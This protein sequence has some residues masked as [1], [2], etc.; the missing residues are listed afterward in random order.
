MNA[1]ASISTSI[2]G[3]INAL[4]STSAVAG[5]HL[6]EHF[7]SGLVLSCTVTI[8]ADPQEGARR[9]RERYGGIGRV[10]TLNHSGRTGT[11]GRISSPRSMPQRGLITR[12]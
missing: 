12:P 10:V 1:C 5:P 8:C 9:R 6:S 11:R 3:P 4:T 2:A 7:S